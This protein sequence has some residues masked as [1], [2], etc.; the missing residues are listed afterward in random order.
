MIIPV[1]DP[2]VKGGFRTQ[3]PGFISPPLVLPTK[4]LEMLA[5]E[6][7]PEIYVDDEVIPVIESPLLYVNVPLLGAVLEKDETLNPGAIMSPVSFWKMRVPA[8]S[9]ISTA[10]C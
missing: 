7:G 10:Y 5:D 9:S 2:A 4:V 8:G 6:G 1:R 3:D